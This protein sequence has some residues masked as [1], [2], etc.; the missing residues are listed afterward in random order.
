[1]QLFGFVDDSQLPYT[2]I[3]I[4]VVSVVTNDTAAGPIKTATHEK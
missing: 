1:M 4:L 2:V 3:L